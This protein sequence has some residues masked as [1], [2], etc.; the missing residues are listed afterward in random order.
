M[1]NVYSSREG[2]S[3]LR[4]AS[5]RWT[6]RLYSKTRRILITYERAAD[7]SVSVVDQYNKFADA[8]TYEQKLPFCG[9]CK[10]YRWGSMEQDGKHP[11]IAMHQKAIEESCR[12]GGSY[13]YMCE[14]GF[15][16]WT[17]PLYTGSR[18]AGALIAGNSLGI[19]KEE[20]VARIQECYGN[21][22]SA[23]QIRNQL[24]MIPERNYEE[25]KAL[26]QMMLICAR[27]ISGAGTEQDYGETRQG[28]AERMAQSGISQGETA[29]NS[30]ETRQGWAGQEPYA[31]V[32]GAVSLHSGDPLR[33]ALETPQCGSVPGYSAG[34]GQNKDSPSGDAPGIL[35][36]ERRLLAALRRGDS[37]AAS[38]TL[39]RIL[40]IFSNM[41]PDD[42]EFFQCRA[43]ELV[44]F[45][46]RAAIPGANLV[47]EAVLEANNRYL[48]KIVESTSVEE[49][50][51]RLHIIVDLMAGKIFSFQGIRHASALRKAEGFI[52]ENYTRKLSL[53]EI[54]GVSGLSAPYF[55]TIFREEMGENLSAYLNRLRV[56][57][58]AGLLT[59]SK[60]T[61]NE[62][63]EACGFEDQSWFS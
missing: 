12:L 5:H 60:A 6:G 27:Q 56:E 37:A 54:A 57:K 18:Y 30:G 28:Y 15:V 31:K 36:V 11:C 55:S 33:G 51:E 7:C 46:S 1:S 40:D 61:L 14:L 26:V 4:M 43:I 62:I 9:L 41:S 59:E 53:E 50:T 19:K 22:L 21:S 20:A 58:A 52:R 24:E 47:D 44:V 10:K 63:A 13:I 29:V 3:S 38:K 2:A 25:T 23:E 35:E 48:K 39:D 16:F 45:L 42:F 34:I 32:S 49:L 8:T 17:S